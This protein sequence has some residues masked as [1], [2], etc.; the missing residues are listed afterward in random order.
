M[1]VPRAT[2]TTAVTVSLR[3]TVQP[4][5]EARSPMTAVSMP[6]TMMEM[7]KHAQPL[8][9]SVGGTKANRIFQKTVTMCKKM[10]FPISA[11]LRASSSSGL[12]LPDT[13][14]RDPSAHPE[15]HPGEQ[16]L[17]CRRSGEPVRGSSSSSVLEVLE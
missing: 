4:K 7:T 11:I 9:Q 1:E 16:G 13:G 3:P 15:H 14:R 12:G 10:G 2:K 8:Q 17:G 5:C 6:M